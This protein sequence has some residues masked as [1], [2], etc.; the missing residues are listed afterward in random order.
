MPDAMDPQTRRAT[1]QIGV[2][3][4]WSRARHEQG[5]ILAELSE[6]FEILHVVEV[7][8]TRALVMQNYRRFYSDIKVRGV[9]HVLKQRARDHA[10]RSRWSIGGRSRR[11]GRRDAG[12][13]S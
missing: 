1:T 6:R 13:V 8:W 3:I 10:L 11:N 12:R 7:R 5:Q 2:F 4:V 9:Y